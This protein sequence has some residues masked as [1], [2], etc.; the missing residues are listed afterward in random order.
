MVGQQALDDVPSQ[1][2]L[3]QR[4]E[5]PGRLEVVVMVQ[6]VGVLYAGANERLDAGA[7]LGPFELLAPLD[8]RVGIAQDR[9]QLPAKH[10]V[11]GQELL[12]QVVPELLGRRAL[13]GRRH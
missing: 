13:I 9:G 6:V 12:H 7:R 8:Q 1:T 11:N 10:V 3:G 2:L 4:R 5:Q